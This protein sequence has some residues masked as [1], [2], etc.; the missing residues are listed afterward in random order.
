MI[1]AMRTLYQKCK[2]VHGDLSEYNILY[3]EGHLYIID[4]SQSVDLDHPHGLDFLREDCVHVSDFFKKHGVA[5]M[6]IRELFDF[7]VDPSITDESMDSYLEEVQQ[8]ILARGDVISQDLYLCRT[9]NETRSPADKRAARK[10]NRKKVKEEKREARK[11][12]VPK[13][14]KKKK[15]K[16]AKAKKYRIAHGNP[17][18]SLPKSLTRSDSGCSL[19]EQGLKPRPMLKPSRINLDRE[20][21]TTHSEVPEIKIPC[22]GLCA[23]IEKLVVCKRYLEALELFEIIECEGSYDLTKSTY[24]ALVNACIGSKSIRGVKRV[25]NY[26]MDS[27]FEPDHYMRN[28]VLLM[29]VKCGMMIDARKLFDEM[30]KRNLISWSMMIAGVV[31]LG[32]YVEAFRLFLTLW[33]E[34]SGAGSR[35]FATMI[36]AASGLELV[37]PGRQLH[38]C[39]L[40]VGVDDNIFVSCALIDMYSKCGSIDDARCVFEEMPEKTTVAWNTI[41]A[42]YAFHGHSEEALDMY[43]EMQDS[44]AKMDQFTFSMIISVCAR[45]ASLEH[46]KQAHA[47]LVRHGYGLDIVAAGIIETLKRKGFRM[48]PVC[49]W[50][51]IKKQPHVFL[52]ADKNHIQMKESHRICGDCH[53]A[54]KLIAMV[55]RREIIVRDASRFHRFKDGNCSCGD[56]W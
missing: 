3:F 34:F 11:T 30:P 20:E 8:K 25:F 32:D 45:L 18:L 35:V 47:G 12:K 4:V 40:K 14:V 48:L 53:N 29:H 21:E 52:S 50:T 42:G 38:S 6:T 44:G 56:Y 16:L 49:T 37:F 13:A 43:Y 46:A 28:R 5:V 19:I 17:I 22:S 1:M 55:T 26:M 23:Q 9:E 27:G 10:E 36:R 2:L 31:D 39:A 54:I 15:K 7:I 24:D 41:I 33:E 51:Q